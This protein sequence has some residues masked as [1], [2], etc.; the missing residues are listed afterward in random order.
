MDFSDEDVQQHAEADRREVD[1][2]IKVET[3]T[4]SKAGQHDWWVKER[5]KWMGRG[6]W[7]GWSATVDQSC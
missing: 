5:G 7:I 3:A 2:A 1:P 6:P 4:W